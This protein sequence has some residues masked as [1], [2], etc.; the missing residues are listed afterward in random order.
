MAFPKEI[1]DLSD[2]FSNLPNVGPKLSNRLALYLSVNA[3]DLAR[4][5]SIKLEDVINNVKS[6]EICGNVSNENICSICKDSSR[7]QSIILVIEDALDLNN[8]E[9]T[10][11]YKGLYH[12]LG[13]VI[14]PINGIGPEELK[15]NDLLKRIKENNVKEVILGLNPNVEGEATSMYLKQE[16]MK[17]SPD[18]KITRLAKGIPS[19]SDLEFV[20]SQT[21]VDSM[22]SRVNF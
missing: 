16:L 18:I 3:K 2:L 15:I 19:G 7:D 11:E 21:I 12:V 17:V 8:I 20:S 4:K 14:S 10:G 13:G 22:K 9:S 5:L 6:C 1:Q